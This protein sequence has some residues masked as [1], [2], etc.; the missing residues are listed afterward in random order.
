VTERKHGAP[1]R[2]PARDAILDAAIAVLAANPRAGVDLIVE[3]AGVGR[4]TLFRYFPGRADV[5]RAAGVRALA[6]LR[7]A[8]RT[9]GLASGTAVARLT[10]L[11]QVLVPA[12]ERLR[13][14]LF[15]SDLFDDPEL[16]TASQE[17]DAVID[18]IIEAAI[19]DGT[20]RADV[21]ALVLGDV[22]ESLLY[23]T[24]TAIEKG[25]LAPADGP[26]TMLELFLHGF[27]APAAA[28]ARRPR[29]AKP[30]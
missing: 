19:G 12:G 13:F 27:G 5:V 30:R 6:E 1:L 14:L 18:P 7:A 9:A 16:A 10:R 21:S 17:V 29:G 3:R 24:W 8:L 15:A 23:G 28:P 2:R 25:H 20:L 26:H 22:L 11:F 4:A